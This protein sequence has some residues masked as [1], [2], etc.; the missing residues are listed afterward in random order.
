LV[1][2][3]KVIFRLARHLLTAT[4]QHY[5]VA[6]RHYLRSIV[7]EIDDLSRQIAPIM[8]AFSDRYVP[9]GADGQLKRVAQRFAL[10]AVG[11]PG[12]AIAAAGRCFSDWL[13]AAVV[14]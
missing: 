9:S 11:E 10:V 12:E 6:A 7:P 1:H 3:G 13:H 5:G 8:Q 4:N 14:T 2:P